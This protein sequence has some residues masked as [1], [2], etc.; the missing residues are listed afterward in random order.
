[1][2]W[3]WDKAKHKNV[4]GSIHNFF[5]T[6][7]VLKSKAPIQHVLQTLR[8]CCKSTADLKRKAT[9]LACNAILSR[10][11]K[12]AAIELKLMSMILCLKMKC[13]VKEN[14]TD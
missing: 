12:R 9:E 4:T 2:P 13:F 3:K 5:Y 7:Y 1:V 14:K 10:L 6:T 11:K 8:L